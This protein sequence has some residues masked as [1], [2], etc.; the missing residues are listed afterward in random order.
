MTSKTTIDAPRKLAN[1]LVCGA[2]LKL[3]ATGIVGQK[4]VLIAPMCPRDTVRYEAGTLPTH[5][6]WFR[7]PSDPPARARR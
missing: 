7:T 5:P 3:R 2:K 1:C 4:Y 6:Y